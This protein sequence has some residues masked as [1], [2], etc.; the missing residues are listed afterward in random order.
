MI[1]ARDYVYF[2]KNG[3][4][5]IKFNF[6]IDGKYI[7]RSRSTKIYNT[8]KR[9]NPDADTKAQM[10]KLAEDFA[11]EL[12]EKFFGYKPSES[13]DRV[14]F[15]DYVDNWL[16]KCVHNKLQYNTWKGYKSKVNCM[17]KYSGFAKSIA[18][19]TSKDINSFFDFLRKEHRE[20]TN[21]ILT[22]NTLLH[23][24]RVLF[25]VFKKALSDGLIERSPL[26][27]V[28][29]PKIEE[30]DYNTF[31]FNEVEELIKKVIADDDRMACVII[32][33]LCLGMRRSEICGLTWKNIDFTKTS[34]YP[35]GSVTI[36]QKAYSSYGNDVEEII[37]SSTMKT[38]SSKRTLPL[39]EVL[40]NYLS[41]LKTKQEEWRKTAGNCWNNKYNG[42]VCI[43]KLGDL[44]TPNYVTSHWRWLCQKY[45]YKVTF[46][47]LRH[48]FATNQIKKGTALVKLRQWL[49]HSNISTTVNVYG[50]I[51]GSDLTDVSEAVKINSLSDN[52][53]TEVDNENYF[54]EGKK[55]MLRQII[56]SKLRNNESNEEIY[57]EF[58]EFG[59]TVEFI[60]QLRNEIC[61]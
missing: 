54:D 34:T 33:A 3:I 37:I 13:D 20:K 23:Y 25:L 11:A 32:I 51:D 43:D 5:Q 36:K 4:W 40:Y 49:G 41:E 45:G 31:S 16:E 19:I 56:Q 38:K 30:I 28:V 15:L 6:T 24:Y 44:I 52:S 50:H 2:T 29:R 18:D 22:E 55:E 60:I 1:D 53:H 47:G 35:H 8:T 10:S 39:P 21:K 42:F 61:A 7:Q 57:N 9:K 17:H 59:V 58:K 46:H 14:M 12:N 27:S 48:T 26:E